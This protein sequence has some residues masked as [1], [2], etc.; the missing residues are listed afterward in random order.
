VGAG[1][2]RQV[3]RHLRHLRREDLVGGPGGGGVA[4]LPSSVSVTGDGGGG[5]T[6]R[7]PV[8]GACISSPFL[9]GFR[10]TGGHS[11]TD[12][13]APTGTPIYAATAGRVARAEW[14][15]AYG[16]LTV[17]DAGNGITAWYA[18]QNVRPTARGAVTAGQRIGVVGSTGNTTG[19]HLHFEVRVDGK[20]VNPETYLPG[21]TRH[22]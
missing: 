1:P 10:S 7:T 13:A 3:R 16:W 11:G 17:V 15:G 6:W 20:P 8:R 12:F 5:G 22:C 18:H 2:S 9:G 19:P 4:P 21:T 14:G